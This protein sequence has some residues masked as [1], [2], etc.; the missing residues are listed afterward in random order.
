MVSLAQ[1]DPNVLPTDYDSILNLFGTG[2]PPRGMTDMDRTYL[3]ALYE[4]DTMLLP[5]AQRGMLSSKMVREQR[6]GEGEE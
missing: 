3:R 1:V 4:M 5:R 2:I 6:E